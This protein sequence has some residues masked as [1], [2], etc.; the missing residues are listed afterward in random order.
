MPLDLNSA[1]ADFDTRLAG[2]LGARQA[3]DS[4]AAEAARTI[5]ADVRA[6]GDAAVIE[7][8]NR[9]DRLS[10]ADADG[11]RLDA[12]RIKA[13][14]AKCPEHVRDALKF[15]AERIR[16]F[17]EY[18]T[19]AGLEL[20][21]PG[22]MMLGYRFTPI[23]AVGLY[24]PGG[25]AAYPSSL[26]MN[27][28]PA[29]VAGVE[30][31]VV[32]VPTPDDVLSPALA[33]AIE[34]LGL[35]EVYRVGGAQAVAA[36]AY[37]TDSIK[38]VDLVVGPG[39]A[40]VAAAKREV[41]GIVGID[42]L[43]GPSEILV[44]ADDSADPDW[45]AADLLSQAE[46]DEQAQSILVTDSTV[47]AAAVGAAVERQLAALP[48]AGIARESWNTHGA[49][50][51]VADLVAEAPVIADRI[52]A[53]H[54]EVVCREAD[55]VVAAIHHAGAIFIGPYSSE[56]IGDY[57]AGTNHVLPT[58]G[59]ARFASGLGVMNFMKRTSLIRCSAEAFGPLAEA[60]IALAEAEGL[61]AHAEAVRLRRDAGAQVRAKA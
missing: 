25:T 53:E 6:R 28:I 52:A 29:Q 5:I 1:D 54:V 23:S 56:P 16:V 13:A 51:T 36:F 19:P 43:A 17:H 37:G 34:L 40:Y 55:A 48:R 50:I 7:L 44:I 45:I 61:D 30:R 4:S 39:N 49:I 31:I 22:G 57:V 3:S 27:T 38:P 18:Q 42:S 33:A 10:I 58:A 14:A 41:Y 26:L 47:L 60:T 21:Q 9:F 20:E 2:L 32:M 35:T 24:V 59:S 15:A 46:H 8:T 12:G 11:L